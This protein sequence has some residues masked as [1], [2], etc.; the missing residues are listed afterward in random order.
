MSFLEFYD[1]VVIDK[2]VLLKLPPKCSIE[3]LSRS[4]KVISINNKIAVFPFNS[5]IVLLYDVKSNDWSQESCEV[6]R[7]ISGFSCLKVPQF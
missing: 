5:N 1:S 3:N 2:Y 6:T 7:N 4:F